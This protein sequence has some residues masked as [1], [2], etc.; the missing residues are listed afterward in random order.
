MAN[1]HITINPL[2]LNYTKQKVETGSF[3]S[4]SELINEAL[5]R[6]M[7]Q[8]ILYNLQVEKLKKELEKGEESKFS[9]LNLEKIYTKALKK[10]KIDK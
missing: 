8:D 3:G 9:E 5:R 1:V 2:L 7:E 4:K 6:M 10:Y